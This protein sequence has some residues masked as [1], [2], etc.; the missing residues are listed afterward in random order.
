MFVKKQLE[1]QESDLDV[2]NS[3][4]PYISPHL[5]SWNTSVETHGSNSEFFTDAGFSTGS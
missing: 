1:K 3:K 2:P 4:L 5:E